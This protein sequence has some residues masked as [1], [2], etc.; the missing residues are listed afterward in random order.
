[1]QAKW[2]YLAQFSHIRNTSFF[3]RKY[4]TCSSIWVQMRHWFNLFIEHL[5]ELTLYIKWNITFWMVWLIE[6]RK[7]I[8]LISDIVGKRHTHFLDSKG[9]LRIPWL[10]LVRDAMNKL[11]PSMCK[12]GKRSR[13]LLQVVYF[14]ITYHTIFLYLFPSGNDN[15][16]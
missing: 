5:S 3:K 6:W 12:A 10:I 8:R 1:M 11:L 4:V 7:K 16:E 15:A 2:F 13:I 9:Y 14:S